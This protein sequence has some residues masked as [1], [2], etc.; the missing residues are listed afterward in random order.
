MNRV[1]LPDNRLFGSFNLQN[2]TTLYIC[3][4]ITFATNETINHIE[5][6]RSYF[7]QNNSEFVKNSMKQLA[8]KNQIQSNK[9]IKTNNESKVTT[10]LDLNHLNNFKIKEESKVLICF[11]DLFSHY[12]INNNNKLLGNNSIVMKCFQN[13]NCSHI[14][15]DCGPYGKG[16]GWKTMTK[17]EVLS[18]LPIGFN[19]MRV[20]NAINNDN[21]L[22]LPLK[23]EL[24]VTNNFQ[25]NNSKSEI[26]ENKLQIFD[27]KTQIFENKT[28][29]FENKTQIFDNKNQIFENKTQIFDNKTQIFENKTQ[30]FENKS[31]RIENK[32]QICMIDMKYYY[33]TINNN[34]KCKRFPNCPYLHYNI[35]SYNNSNEN[36]NGNGNGWKDM[37]KTEILSRLPSDTLDRTIL[38]AIENDHTLRK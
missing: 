21:T 12:N 27:N 22:R 10:I 19:D 18:N 29:I 13:S 34:G 8:S 5:K 17:D 7:K 26:F 6:K 15:Y 1:K 25:I 16:H 2:N 23:S 32:T 24:N 36:K 37:T 33:N 28:Q 11:Y 9:K 3:P 38:K 31:N 35:D 14:H 30:L 4:D 20:L